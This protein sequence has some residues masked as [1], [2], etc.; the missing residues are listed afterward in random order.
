[1]GAE[2]PRQPAGT[3][4]NSA[5]DDRQAYLSGQLHTET[6]TE[7]LSARQL[8]SRNSLGAKRGRAKV[9]IPPRPP[10]PPRI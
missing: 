8:G 2:A 5:V 3:A 9:P 6:S 7:T 10:F 4:P 1:M